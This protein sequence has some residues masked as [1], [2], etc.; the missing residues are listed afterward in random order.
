MRSAFGPGRWRGALSATRLAGYPLSSC[1]LYHGYPPNARNIVTCQPH[2]SLCGCAS[3][4][5]VTTAEKI[6]FYRKRDGLTR[7]QLAGRVGV[8]PVTVKAWELGLFEPGY[9]NRKALARAFKITLIDIESDVERVP[10]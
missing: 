5:V 8:K 2:T 10:A 1:R 3:I 6:A 9:G 4:R 7:V